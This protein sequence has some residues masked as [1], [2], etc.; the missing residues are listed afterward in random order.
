[1]R[2]LGNPQNPDAI[3]LSDFGN[4]D[5]LVAVRAATNSDAGSI[6]G[7]YRSD[8]AGVEALVRDSDSGLQLMT[9]GPF[10]SARFN[11]EA[12]AEGVWRARSVSSMSWGGMLSFDRQSGDFNFGTS[13]TRALKFRRCA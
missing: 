11:L 9:V 4:F 2:I 5:E 12:L 10:G 6:R 3:R 13:R 7:R 8:S 1:V